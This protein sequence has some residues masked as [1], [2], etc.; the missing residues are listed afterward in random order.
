MIDEKT[1]EEFQS[2]GLLLFIN[3]ILHVFGWAL[4]LEVDDDGNFI[5][6]FPARTKFRG[7]DQKSVSKSYIKISKYI[8]KNSEVLLNEAEE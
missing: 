7:F 2:T 8:K 5:R 3:Q 1:L 4:V 6:V